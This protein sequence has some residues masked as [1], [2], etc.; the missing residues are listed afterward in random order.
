MDK[1]ADYKQTDY[2]Q[3]LLDELHD[4]NKTYEGLL[5][6]VESMQI[7]MPKPKEGEEDGQNT[8]N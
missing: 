2:T 5:K 3:N 8:D 6:F 7:S 1:P 4:L